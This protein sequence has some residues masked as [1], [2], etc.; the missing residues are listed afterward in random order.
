VREC[1]RADAFAGPVVKAFMHSDSHDAD[2]LL[3]VA[4]ALIG[5]DVVEMTQAGLGYVEICPAGTTKATGLAKVAAHLGV[6]ADDVLVFG[7]M[8]NDLP[9]FG[10]AGWGRV[11]VANAHRE[12]LAVAEEITLSNDE[13]GVAVYVE[14]VLGEAERPAA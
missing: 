8:P 4:R 12:L 7:D 9:M 13:D 14:R 2:E 6:A 1:S 3:A 10:W 5:P 11:A